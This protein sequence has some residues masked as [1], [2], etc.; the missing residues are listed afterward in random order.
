MQVFG[1]QPVGFSRRDLLERS[2]QIR[3]LAADGARRK[4]APQ[5]RQ[6]FIDRGPHGR[7]AQQLRHAPILRRLNHFVH[8]DPEQSML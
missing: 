4:L 1:E 5:S 6:P 7:E 3:E 2:V 8:A